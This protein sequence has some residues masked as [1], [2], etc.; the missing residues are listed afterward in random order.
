VTDIRQASSGSWTTVPGDAL[1][2]ARGLL[3]QE[4]V[5]TD[6]RASSISG[7]PGGGISATTG[8]RCSKRLPHTRYDDLSIPDVVLGLY[9]WVIAWDHRSGP[10]GLISTASRPPRGAG[11][12]CPSSDGAGAGTTRWKAGR[13][14]SG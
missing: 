14:E 9:D 12:A 4:P 7:R 8:A 1:T 11:S 3:P 10:H 2:V 6:L 13:R 5:S